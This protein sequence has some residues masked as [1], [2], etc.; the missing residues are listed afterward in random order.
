[1]KIDTVSRKGK[2]KKIAQNN[3]RCKVIREHQGRW[4]WK[5]GDR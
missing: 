1:M 3:G 2:R 5:V 4:E